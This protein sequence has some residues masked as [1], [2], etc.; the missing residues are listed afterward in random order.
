MDVRDLLIRTL[1]GEAGNQGPEG[2]AAVA[3]VIRNRLASGKYGPDIQSVVTAPKQFSVW[4]PGNRAG[5]MARRVS[6]SD[7]VYQ[8]ASSIA[9]SVFGG[10]TPDPTRGATHYFN[11]SIVQPAWG[12]SMQGG[13]Q[14]GD[15]VFGTAAGGAPS[16]ATQV[17][18]RF[19]MRPGP[20]YAPQSNDETAADLR[21]YFEGNARSHGYMKPDVSHL[22]LKFLNDNPYGVG[23]TSAD[24]DTAKQA[25][26][27]ADFK[28]NGGA[29]VAR[30]G[31]SQ[32]N[33]GNALDLSYED[34]NARKWA[35]QNAK[36]YGLHFPVAGEDWHVEPVEARGKGMVLPDAAANAGRPATPG[37][38]DFN[39]AGPQSML[40]GGFPAPRQDDTLGGLL[41]GL[42]KGGTGTGGGKSSQ[43][44]DSVAV[45]PMITDFGT[46]LA[47]LAK[48]GMT[49][50]GADAY[51]QAT[52]PRPPTGEESP[53]AII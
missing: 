19:A 40:G 8:T 31:H 42:M 28:A 53:F 20:D 4:N 35:Q 26:L 18:Q 30:P 46:L 15:H 13:T 51:R 17:A 37:P 47:S 36:N 3:H 41:S 2:K 32:H 22:F 21:E 39:S 1:I 45:P 27:Y 14:I 29:P 44:T 16:S 48:Q 34:D 33:K 11:P 50:F 38:M 49:S 12:G 9:D 25:A 24:R 5:E 52:M 10:Q 43:S 6:T 7:P 23:I